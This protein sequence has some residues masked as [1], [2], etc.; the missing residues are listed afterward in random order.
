MKRREIFNW[1]RA[2][3]FCIY[4]LQ[5]THCSENTTAT[6]SSEWG[7]KTLFS[8]CSG[9][10][11]GVAIFFNNNFA[12]E[13]QRSYS[14]PKGR[15]IIC[16]IKTNE[17]L[18]TLATIYAPNDDDPAFFES[19]FSHL[20]DFHCDDIVLGGDFN[21]VLNLEKDKKGGLAKTHTKAVNVINDHAT[22]FDLVDAWRVSNP[23]ILRYTW[24]RRRPEIYCRLD[25]FLVSR[26]LMCNV[27]HTDILAGFKTDHSMVTI[28]V[29]LHT[30]PRGPGFWKLNTSFLSETEYIKQIKTTI[31][32]VK[33]EY[34]NDKSVNVSLLWEM[35]KLKVREQTLR[36]AKTKK[37]KMLREEEEL[38]KKI[39]ILQRQI[40]SGCNN[41]NEKLAID[42]QLDQKTKELEKI[43]EHRTKGAIL[44]AK[45]RWYNEG[46][47]NS[48]YF[49]SLEKR[50]Y[51]NGVISQLK[52]G[53]N[54]FAC[55]DKEIL[56]ECETFY[57]DIYSSKADRDNSRIN[58]L[59][60]GDAPPKSLN[61]EEKEKCE[62]ILTKAEC[63]Q[64]L[65]S[66][67][68]GKTPGSDGLPVEFYNV[69]W[70]EISD[71]LLNTINYSYTEGKF[72]IS[73]RRGIIKLIPKKDAEPYF[74]KNWRP[75]TLLNSDYK[76]AAKAIA[77]RLQNVL[78]KLI[79]SD[80][81]GFLKGRFIG[82]NI[83]LIDGLINHTAARNI[84][85]LL[86]FLDFEKAFD[87]VEWSFIWK[88]LSSF[89]FGPSLISWIKLCYCS[90]ES[91]VLNNGWASSYFTPERGV[92][93]GCP[94]SPYIFILC[95]EVLANKIRENKDI[96]GIT[97]RG[98]EIKIS[99]YADDTTMILDGSKKSFTSALLDLELF[100][101]ISGLRLNSKKTEI[102]WIGAC[103]G[104]QD[105]LCPEKDLKWV[106][107]K[108]KALGVW[109]SSDPMVSM[110]AN[111]NEKLLKIRN[112][113]SCW[114]YRRLSLLGKIVVL[115]SLIASQLVYILSPLPTKH[116]SLD[117]INNMFYDFLW[118]GRGDKIKR[119]VMISDYKNGG[120]RMIDIKSFNKAL[121]STWVKKYLDNN[122]HGKW[123]LLL[124]S[125]IYD[126][127]GDVIFK[128]NLNKSD[129]A[130]FIHI[131]DAFTSEI[132]KIWSEI[133]YN[134]NIIS[135]EHLLSL[136]LWQNSLV[137]IGNKPVYYK[138]WSSKGIQIVRH[139]MKDAH[140][141]LSFT[142][143]KERF[144]VKT[145]FL[146]YQGLVSCI[147]L[148]RKAIK[149][150][151]ETNRNFSTFVENFIKA[152]KSNRLAYKKLV[153]AKQSS[154][155][156]SQEKWSADC[157]LQC[158]KTI[159]WEMTYKLPFYSTK[160]T[161]LI[162]FQFK[163][164]HRRL[165]TNDFLNKIGIRENDICTFCRSEKES[166]FHLFWSCSETS[167]FWRDFMKW[168]AK[169]H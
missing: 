46:E 97:V 109:I 26:S 103:T 19:F 74:V 9:A 93:Q 65:K 49:L 95:A 131:S 129:L 152:P 72:S 160:A 101:E 92:R 139:L 42:I 168:L 84:P 102:L 113:L 34:Q 108:L 150:Q 107:D 28:Q 50:H 29:A 119:D 163:L 12:F 165:A 159:D 6:W 140:N 127:G 23:D 143:L 90:I 104:R 4:L 120:L 47:K 169:N 153:S 145:N 27:T 75:I 157:N 80:Q 68:S 116:A 96:K 64:A 58:D 69:F 117:E 24:R 85:G 110:E 54:D 32:S 86:M 137:R 14:D 15:F 36:Y 98:N 128:G 106:T 76:I 8:C 147:K 67:K 132:L 133:S 89:N 78:P 18:F 130:K 122:N 40:D 56:S 60:F 83:R 41:A 149:N 158:S 151:N 112:C 7:Y 111:Y 53:D 66:M 100:G 73:Q 44:R 162:I 144:D 17:R 10:S 22:K 62:G 94:L 148:L 142:E 136:P 57:R 25:F 43:I 126:L 114:E 167:S 1:L 123:K 31:E 125:E 91:C 35:I 39:N 79:N 154:P 156:R 77:N 2:K 164:L 13:F 146:V 33:D 141:F 20:R 5:E 71:C 30:N 16:D 155:R 121:K 52:L 55:S 51:K 3:K 87:S 166:V 21:L 134:G 48:K 81:T 115:K 70:N 61:L 118:S 124:D 59:F 63:L 88:T 161:K 138:S 37:A 105:K 82:E 45:C 135:T 99:Q 11:G 38:E